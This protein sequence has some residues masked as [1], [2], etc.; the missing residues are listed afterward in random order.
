M[1]G[2]KQRVSRRA[3]ASAEAEERQR[4]SS[5]AQQSSSAAVD[6]NQSLYLLG[7]H[8]A[9]EFGADELLFKLSSEIEQNLPWAQ[10]Q[11]QLIRRLNS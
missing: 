3:P 6:S 9:A 8:L 7:I 5:G 1:I 10:K 11:Q 4:S 2:S